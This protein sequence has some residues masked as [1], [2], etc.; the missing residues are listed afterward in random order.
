MSD[1]ILEERIVDFINSYNGTQ[2]EKLEEIRKEAVF[3]GVPII[4][5]EMESFIKTLLSIVKPLN[6]L[7]LGTAVG[8]SSILMSR[9]MPA[10]S[11]ITTIENYPPRICKAKENFHKVGVTDKITLL[12][13]DAEEILKELKGQYDFVFMDAAKGQYM[14]YLKELTRLI[15]TGGVLL[16]DN[17]FCDGDVLESRFAVTRRNRTIHTRMREYLYE[18]TH[19]QLFD[20]TLIP[21]GDG[22]SLSVRK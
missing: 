3:D 20:T 5:R 17:I 7:E 8:Y 6:I 13:S 12:E 9:Y 11:H 1:M 19:S 21:L 2:D 22:V 18:I 14:N 4:R 16:T 15:P 10:A